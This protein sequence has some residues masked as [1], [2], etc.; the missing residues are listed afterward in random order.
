MYAATVLVI[1]MTIPGLAL[2]YGGLV[3]SKNM[4][5]VLM[6]VFVIFSL[7]SVL[8]VIYG[9]ALAFGGPGAFYGNFSKLF[10]SGVNGESAA[11]TFSKGV[12]IPELLF[13]AFQCTFAAI[14]CALIVG[15]YA[16]RMKFSAVL[17]FTV[18]WFTFSYLP[19][20]HMVWYWDG[21]DAIK[22][23]ATLDAVT[24]N[25][26]WLWAKGALDFAGGTVVHINAG[27]AGLVAA[28]VLGKRI[29]YGKESM[30]PHSLTLT[31]VGAAL[32]WVGWFGFN[33]GSNLEAN[34]VAAF[35]F[36][37]TLLA[38]AV[39]VLA[40]MFAEWMVKG[41]PSMLGAASGA[42]AGLVAITPACGF[43]GIIGALVIGIAAGL[44]VLLGCHRPEEDAQ[45]GRRTRRVR[46]ARRRR[47]RRG[48][49][50]RR[51][52]RALAGRRG[53]LQLHHQQVRRR[54]GLPWHWRAGMGAV[55]GRAD[56]DHPVGG[57]IA[58]RA[59][60]GQDDHRAARHARRG[61]RRPRYDVSR[62]IRLQDVTDVRP[63]KRFPGLRAPPSTAAADC[64]LCLPSSPG[65]LIGPIVANFPGHLRVPA[66]FPAWP[67]SRV[68]RG[69][70]AR[71]R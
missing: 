19:M 41:K 23:Q 39:A 62:R 55:P 64:R 9:Y 6:Q 48:A 45:R 50:D 58:G 1:L 66:S 49:A 13:V 16:E 14:T 31:M 35:A 40:W 57:G 28:Y 63:G 33:A 24:A 18:L 10:L 44:A 70:A 25:A 8:W 42:V 21:P 56:C 29:G 5:S 68:R 60:P 69:T 61:A 36:V 43:V 59:L 65:R 2:F 7:I 4:L 11:A 26:G 71:R 15:A 30:A 32:L 20:A 34:G 27:V 53:H 17:L 12:Y 67:R 47:H 51:V 22:D 46:C 37:N 52:R 3:R 38:T 54:G